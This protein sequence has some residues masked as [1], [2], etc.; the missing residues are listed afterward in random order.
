[1]AALLGPACCA[2]RWHVGAEGTC[3]RFPRWFNFEP[4]RM[5]YPR[6]LGAVPLPAF[7]AAVDDLRPVRGRRCVTPEARDGSIS[8][9]LAGPRISAA[10]G[11]GHDEPVGGGRA[12]ADRV[13]AR[14]AGTRRNGVRF[15]GTGAIAIRSANGR[16]T[17]PRG[18]PASPS[19]AGRSSRTRR[20]DVPPAAA[21]APNA[22]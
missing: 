5:G 20:G 19:H 8:K 4:S 1:T 9:H 13:S 18:R 17:P 6:G 14:G 10:P 3:P 11:R 2:G 15:P 21:R 16:G 7:A 12:S 22:G